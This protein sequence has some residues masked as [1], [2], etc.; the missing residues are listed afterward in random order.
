M[1]INRCGYSVTLAAFQSAN[2]DA[3]LGTLAT[4]QTGDLTPAQRDAWLRQIEILKLA[5]NGIEEGTVH[6]EFLIPRMGKRAD[7]V[8][9]IAGLLV[10]I[11]FKVGAQH[12][13][14]AAKD[15]AIDYALDL[16]NFHA[17]SH[18]LPIVPILVATDA[19]TQPILLGR[20]IDNVYDI[21][22]ANATTL[23]DAINAVTSRHERTQFDYQRWL[24]AGYHPT[25][26]IVEASQ[27]LYR[28]HS[29]AEIT[30]MEAGVENLGATTSTLQAI[31][32]KARADCFKAICFVTGVPGAGKTL[33]GLNLASLRRKRKENEEEHA[34]FLSGNGPLVKVLQEALARD[35]V[36]QA[37]ATGKRT[38][39]KQALREAHAFI[40][41]IHHFRDESLKDLNPPVER[42]VVFDE[43]QR[44]WDRKQTSSFMRKRGHSDF[45]QSEPAFLIS[46]MDRYQDWSIIVC[47]VGNG[48]EIN[49]GEAGLEEWLIALRDRFPN[50][51]IYLPDRKTAAGFVPNF[52]LDQLN[53]RASSEPTLHLSVSLRSF[54]AER[55]SKGVAALLHCESE[56]AREEFAAS[57]SQFPIRVTRSID[58]AKNWIRG[59]ARGTERIGLL[60]SSGAMRLK[61]LGIAMG[62]QV[63]P[64]VWFLNGPEDVRSSYYLED[65]ASEFDVQGLELDWAVI[66]WDGDLI[67]EP[68][69]NGWRY[70]EFTGTKWNQIRSA[71]GQRYRL[72]AYRVLLTRARQGMAIVVP[73]GDASD[74]TRT[75]S[76]YDPTWNYLLSIGL[77]QLLDPATPSPALLPPGSSQ[78]SA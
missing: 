51:Q 7:C 45:D 8:L 54:R 6:F 35:Q 70:R 52:N 26:T 9:T 17:G 44:A 37:R 21:L 57:G 12:Y 40:Q 11:E 41:N 24:A 36:Q 59:R 4:S 14:R 33:A 65:A 16:R 27:V 15:Q 32:D 69:T 60:A 23:R 77:P 43:A 20:S 56:T 18:Q 76:F 66:V 46:V 1:S 49:T 75:P 67:Y 34:V 31:I 72:N 30:R 39:K 47:L 48:Q 13:D 29:V 64:C 68:T 28:T 73:E 3:I 2:P 5:L 53:L 19:P 25:P 61:P 55:I 38:S 71:A 50:W 22:L 42:V 62:L 74:P 10:V 78:T 58:L 63:D